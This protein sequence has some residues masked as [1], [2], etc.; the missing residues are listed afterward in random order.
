MRRPV[1]DVVIALTAATLVASC[2]ASPTGAPGDPAASDSPPVSPAHKA[3]D[4]S[5]DPHAAAPLA[6]DDEAA[7]VLPTGP[8]GVPT[9]ALH[10]R[11]A[12]FSHASGVTVYD[13]AS[14][15]AVTDITTENTPTYDM[16][17]PRELSRK[18]AEMIRSR[19]STPEPVQIGGAPAMITVVPVKLAPRGEGSAQ[20]GFEVIAA[21]ADDGKPIWRLPV[22]VYGEPTGKL[23]A[24]LV[25]AVDGAAAVTWTEDGYSAGTFAVSLDEPRL[26][27]QR[28]GF[29]M[30]GGYDGALLGFHRNADDNY[31]MAGIAVPDG[32]DLWHKEVPA[33]TTWAI[34]ET[35]GPLAKLDDDG[36]KGQLIELATGDIALSKQG[37]LTKRMRCDRGEGGTVDLCASKQDGALAVDGAGKVLWRR[38]AGDGPDDWNATAEADFKDLAYAKGE[39][40]AFVIDART[41]RTVSTDAGVAPDRVNA[42]AALVFTDKGTEVHHTKR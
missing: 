33:N 25:S 1:R 37:G 10:G 7:H 20:A 28:A 21:R 16:P 30:I 15:K 29:W 23:G 34:R 14:G 39:E 40:G 4:L 26:L 9:V 8:K 11:A 19:V 24:L 42:Y 17:A 5:G 12:W 36:D 31:V 22:D 2:T 27:W 41:G 3:L 35:G 6:F 18:Q 13:L 32:R 38:S